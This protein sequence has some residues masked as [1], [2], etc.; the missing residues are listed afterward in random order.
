MGGFLQDEKLKQA[1]FKSVSSYFS[2]AARLE[3]VYKEL[4]RAHCLPVEFAEQNLLPEIR[5]AAL[6]YFARHGIKWHD[7]LNGRPSNH[8]CDSQVCCVN[9]LFPFSDKP[10]ALA[11]VLRP[12]FPDI[13]KMLP[14][15]DGR[16]VSFEW[17]GAKN[18]LI[19]RISRSGQRTRGANFTS[20]DAIVMFE[21]KDK[22]RQIVLI[23]WKYTESY[24]GTSLKYAKSGTDRSKIYRHLYESVDCP[25]DKE[26]LPDFDALFYNP[27]DQLMRLQF[28]AHEMERAHEMGAQVVSLLHISPAANADFQRVTAPKL[29]RIGAS[30][31]EVWKTL[32]KPE[33]RFISVSSEELFGKIT[34]TQLPKMK[35]WIEY[36]HERY[37]WLN[38]SV[39]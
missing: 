10:D 19:E 18:Y 6:A 14:V 17:I 28:L 12:V 13:K 27:F 23:E 22:K 3:G 29:E 37:A 21:R 38:V 25:L 26:I 16:Y 36:I 2:D 7:G 31:L 20:A 34:A 24:S 39:A 4:P 33:G 35:S 1:Q 5:E 30:V 32:V 8:L 15:E 9:F 11:R